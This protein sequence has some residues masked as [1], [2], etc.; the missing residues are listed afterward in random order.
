MFSWRTSVVVALLLSGCASHPVAKAAPTAI[1]IVIMTPRSN[2]IHSPGATT[3]ER[4]CTNGD[5]AACRQAAFA[6][7]DQHDPVQ[8]AL[9]AGRATEL[10][11]EACA[12][13]DLRACNNLAIDYHHAPFGVA[14]PPE[15]L[16][17]LR[18]ACDGGFAR[19]CQNLANI[20]PSDALASWR[21]TRRACDLGLGSSCERLGYSPPPGYP[22]ILGWSFAA[23][24][25]SRA[26]DLGEAYSCLLLSELH[27]EGKGVDLDSQLADTLLARACGLYGDGKVRECRPRRTRPR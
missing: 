26:C 11:R 22:L 13:D 23:A 16:R 8:A 18:H 6:R 20:S 25:W 24:A 3:S 2:R 17:L 10:E 12:R 14:D 1:R 19:A 9:F 21:L 7:M 27:R 5:P 4:A 15:A